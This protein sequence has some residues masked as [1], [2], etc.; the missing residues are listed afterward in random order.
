MAEMLE[1]KVAHPLAGA[2]CAWVPSPT[3]AT[4]HALHYLRVNVAERQR[5]LAGRTTD[6]RL[7]LHVPVL[8]ERPAPEVVE[9]ELRT[10]AQ[11]IL[12]YVV[13][14]VGL[15]IGC[16]TVPD[17]AGVGLMEDRATLR[18]SSQ[19]IANWLHHDIVDENQVRRVFAEMA[20]LVDLQNAGEPGYVPMG[21]DLAGSEPFQAALELVFAG[22][23]EP[24]GYTERTLTKWRRLAKARAAI[25]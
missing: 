14:W 24:N 9:H 5:E 21:A 6:R 13:R 1:Q 2:N 17:L 7:L 19:H 3:A 20:D 16:S 11:S 8:A 15:G 25:S 10:N 12:G 22:R 18:I 23:A 4:L